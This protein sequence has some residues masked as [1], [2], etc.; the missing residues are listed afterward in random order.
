MSE[1]SRIKTTLFSEGRLRAFKDEWQGLDY[2]KFQQELDRQQHDVQI[3]DGVILAAQLLLSRCAT[4]V[5][6]INLDEVDLSEWHGK[7][8]HL[9]FYG[10]AKMLGLND[11]A[12][13]TAC[14]Y[15]I[16][17]NRYAR[18]VQPTQHVL[19]SPPDSEGEPSNLTFRRGYLSS[20][21]P[22]REGETMNS[23]LNCLKTSTVNSCQ[24]RSREGFQ[25][26]LFG[27]KDTPYEF[28]EAFEKAGFDF[29]DEPYEIGGDE[30][31]RLRALEEDV[32]KRI[33][34][35]DRYFWPQNKAGTWSQFADN[36]RQMS[37]SDER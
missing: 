34:F 20:F 37:L 8:L 21:L 33:D 4:T 5:E 16:M 14:Q 29:A 17:V 12:G 25:Y 11:H 24:G 26:Y 32:N 23:L 36:I 3:P 27:G 13:A 7:P 28:T 22:V 31:F 19:F 35:V 30:L 18:G 1:M 9:Q 15:K 2:P 10:S 6:F